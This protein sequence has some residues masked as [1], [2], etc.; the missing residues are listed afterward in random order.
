MSTPNRWLWVIAALCAGLPACAARENALPRDVTSALENAF[1]R[2]DAAA[3]AKLFTDDA[4]ILPESGQT[5]RGRPQIEEYL[6]EQVALE[7]AFDT[8]ATTQLVRD[9]VAIE[10]GTYRVR[11]VVT[12]KD[13]EFGKYMHVWK[14]DPAGGWKIFRLMQNTDVA[15]RASVSVADDDAR[16]DAAR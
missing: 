16:A 12:G 5:I 9:D 6:K 13:V 8:D 15:P 1:N 7:T 10:Q 11:N 3:A 2:N 4:E 14:K